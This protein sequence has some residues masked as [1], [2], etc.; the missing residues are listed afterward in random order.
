[1]SKNDI[2]CY[3]GLRPESLRRALHKLQNEGMIRNNSKSIDLLNMETH[4]DMLC[5]Q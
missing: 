3:L 1:M 2:A 4:I 5:G